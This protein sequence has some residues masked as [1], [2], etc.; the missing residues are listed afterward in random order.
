VWAMR[1]ARVRRGRQRVRTTTGDRRSLVEDRAIDRV[2]DDRIEEDSM[3]AMDLSCSWL[4]G[5][6]GA[7]CEYRTPL[8]VCAGDSFIVDLQVSPPL[9]S[10]TEPAWF[11][12]RVKGAL[13][14]LRSNPNF[15]NIGY[16]VSNASG[17][18][19]VAANVRVTGTSAIDRDS[20]QDIIS[21]ILIALQSTIPG[22]VT[23]TEPTIK[24]SRKGKQ[25]ASYKQSPAPSG[26]SG[27]GGGNLQQT[28]DKY[29]PYAIIGLMALVLVKAI[30]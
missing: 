1:D 2:G 7:T 29:M 12:D 3:N 16:Q 20:E 17:I 28:I 27:G 9:L 22:L 5:T 23:Q 15:S 21:D 13:D 8:Y 6:F 4:Q 14:Q 26:G 30:D 24:V 25:T 11:I 18:V 19:R 10:F